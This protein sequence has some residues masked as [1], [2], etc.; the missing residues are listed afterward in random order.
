MADESR[1]LKYKNLNKGNMEKLNLLLGEHNTNQLSN[2]FVTTEKSE[3]NQW[4]YSSG[5]MGARQYTASDSFEPATRVIDNPYAALNIHDHTNYY[6]MCGMAE[7]ALLMNGAYYRSR[8]NDYRFTVSQRI[9]DLNLYYHGFNSIN[10]HTHKVQ[11][12]MSELD[13]EDLMA[14]RVPY[15][16]RPTNPDNATHTHWYWVSWNG[17]AFVFQQ[18]PDDTGHTHT[19]YKGPQSD[20]DKPNEKRKSFLLAPEP[21]VSILDL[22]TGVDPV[23]GAVTPTVGT[24]AEYM[25]NIWED[26]PQDLETYLTYCEMWFEYIDEEQG[27]PDGGT[28]FRHAELAGKLTEAYRRSTR[29]TASGHKNRLENISVGPAL[30]VQIEE[31]GTPV[32]ANPVFRIMAKRIGNMADKSNANRVAPTINV[33]I[34]ASHGH[35]IPNLTDTQA[36]DLISGGETSITL[37]TV[38]GSH[39]HTYDVTWDSGSTTFLAVQ[40]DGSGHVHQL[41]ITQKFGGNLP[42][43]KEQAKAGTISNQ[44]AFQLIRDLS[45]LERS[46]SLDT[47]INSRRARFKVKDLEVICEMMPGLDGEGA[48]LTEAHTDPYTGDE[49]FLV[50]RYTEEVPMNAAYYNREYKFS[51]DASGRKSAMRGFNDP[52]LFVASTSKTDVVNGY[53]YMFPLEIVVRSPLESWNPLDIPFADHS[54]LQQQENQNFGSLEGFPLD[55]INYRHFYFT[56]PYGLYVDPNDEGDL[57]DTNKKAWVKT[58]NGDSVLAWA[59]GTANFTHD[60]AHR[61]RFPCYPL[62]ADFSYESS[63]FANFKDI[64][65]PI[66]E[67]LRAG[68]ATVDDIADAF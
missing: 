58:K 27:V 62:S 5:I 42:Y 50:D 67:A 36:Q 17:S 56:T 59:G 61:V 23:T 52:N 10:D 11:W 34:A 33:G 29:L 35:V 28:S 63:Q 38:G 14:G 25:Q 21:K 43:D 54:H 44:N 39:T 15:F 6:G 24:Q 53:S 2:A 32:Y 1:E 30:I 60:L 18:I 4:S 31:D 68:T 45:T 65:K 9:G 40:T 46:G 20:H 49:D 64:L 48:V 7:L 16:V 55:G 41:L 3:I 66:L 47:L 22:P 19:M 12:Q 8:H 51:T 26:N 57:A 13:A 37:T